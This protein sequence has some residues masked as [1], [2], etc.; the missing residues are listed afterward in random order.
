MD[1]FL[2]ARTIGGQLDSGSQAVRRRRLLT[3]GIAVG[4]LLFAGGAAQLAWTHSPQAMARASAIGTDQAP[5]RGEAVGSG[6]DVPTTP[7]APSLDEALE[8]ALLPPDA[9]PAVI[10]AWRQ[11]GRLD[12]DQ[13]VA[14]ADALLL[15]AR[16]L[17]RS[18]WRQRAGCFTLAGHLLLDC[19]ESIPAEVERAGDAM[20]VAMPI[21]MQNGAGAEAGSA[22]RLAR[23]SYEQI[24]SDP[25]VS[26]RD[27][28]DAVKRKLARVNA[29][30]PDGTQENLSP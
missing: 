4:W 1:R 26:G 2:E 18:A 27:M 16:E 25:R 24:L 21:Y 28:V 5:G 13:S 11:S 6:A 30:S 12:L 19:C 15:H 20:L 10:V 9:M 7:N 29:A 3:G 23:R 22:A 17:G 8:A 14:L